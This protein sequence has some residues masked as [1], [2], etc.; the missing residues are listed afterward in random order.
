MSMYNCLECGYT[1]LESQDSCEKCS[2]SYNVAGEV[3]ENSEPVCLHCSSEVNAEEHYCSKCGNVVGKYTEYQP[4][5]GIRF[6]YS[7]YG[8]LWKRIWGKNEVSIFLKFLYLTFLLFF[9]PFYVLFIPR[10]IY[11]KLKKPKR[12]NEGDE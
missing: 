8:N 12:A 6:S 10:E 5:E 7:I 11:K 2:W 4:Y 9:V 1:I 3:S